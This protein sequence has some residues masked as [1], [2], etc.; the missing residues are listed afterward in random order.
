[1]PFPADTDQSY[2]PVVKIGDVSEEPSIGSNVSQYGHLP[3]LA[4]VSPELTDKS[5]LLGDFNHNKATQPP[6]QAAS[7]DISS[8]RWQVSVI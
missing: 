3:Y 5:F 1:M 8:L 2:R 7:G 6:P 4:A